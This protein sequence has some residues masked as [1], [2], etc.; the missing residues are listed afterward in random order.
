MNV[1]VTVANKGDFTETFNA[2][3][4]ANTTAI[5][6]K[7]IT[8]ESGASATITFTWN[9]TGYAK[10]NYT[11]WAYAEPVQGET[12]IADNM[13]V[14]GVV[15]VTKQGDVNGDGNVNVLDLI[16]VAGALGTKPGDLKWK[17]NADVKE[18]N[19]INVLD[20]ILVATKLGT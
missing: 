11:I 12:E 4:Y 19:I 2:T 16:V 10:G 17:P 20:L 18:D 14:D 15:Q 6:T 5:E 8:L 7:Q 3:L 9:T 13:F 1:N